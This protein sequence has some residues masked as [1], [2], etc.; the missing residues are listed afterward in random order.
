MIVCSAKHWIYPPVTHQRIHYRGVGGRSKIYSVPVSTVLAP[1]IS[2]EKI[3]R[4]FSRFLNLKMK[5]GC[6]FFISIHCFSSIYFTLVII[7]IC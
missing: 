4:L 2:A 3:L 1:R 5:M 7:S 6:I